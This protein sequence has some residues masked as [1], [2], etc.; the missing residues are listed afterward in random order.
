MESASKPSLTKKRRKPRRSSLER[1]SK[2]RGVPHPPPRLRGAA[3]EDVEEKVG[4]RDVVPDGRDEC[5]H[6][7]RKLD[8][9]LMLRK[10]DVDLQRVLK[11]RCKSSMAF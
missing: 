1:P 9:I 2:V 5:D 6:R 4:L 3:E 10:K 11:V 8:L 7:W